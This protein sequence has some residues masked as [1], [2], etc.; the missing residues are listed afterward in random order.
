ESKDQTPE[1]GRND[2]VHLTGLR[3]IQRVT[4]E[5]PTPLPQLTITQ[6]SEHQLV[7]EWDE[8]HGTHGQVLVLEFEQNNAPTIEAKVGI[9]VTPIAVAPTGSDANAGTTS[10]PLRTLTAAFAVASSHDLVTLPAGDYPASLESVP[11][12]A[13][14]TDAGSY[15]CNVPV[16]VALSGPSPTT[17]ARIFDDLDAG[18]AP[19][20]LCG[21][22]KV[23][24]VEVDGFDVGI[25]VVGNGDGF[26][27]QELD[28]IDITGARNAGLYAQAFASGHDVTVESC[29]AGAVVARASGMQ[30][31]LRLSNAVFDDNLG[32]GIV[33]GP[34]C[35]V[36]LGGEVKRNGA[37]SDGGLPGVLLK[38]GIFDPQ[39]AVDIEDNVGDGIDAFGPNPELHSAGTISG[40]RNGIWY[41][42]DG[43]PSLQL[44]GTAITGN[45]EVG[46]RLSG[47]VRSVVWGNTT[48]I[49]PQPIAG[50]RVNVQVDPD[51][52]GTVEF[53][54]TIHFD[55]NDGGAFPDADASG[56]ERRNWSLNGQLLID[57][58][59]YT[60]GPFDWD[61]GAGEGPYN[62]RLL[63]DAGRI[64]F[65]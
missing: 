9:T 8:P 57:D 61:A 34:G 25:A 33:I 32:C 35:D 20:V 4:V 15:P 65:D 52:H 36:V 26:T 6:I 56:H 1:F 37:A 63:S 7:A 46:L 24:N 23:S 55:P 42:A 64:K 45:R 22:N 59:G 18:G 54:R 13:D 53:V 11:R 12:L 28:D 39:A 47:P 17:K 49:D 5:P 31:G 2:G 21:G 41:A 40:N 10:A 19:L 30:C 27:T 51:F 29:G 50:N 60:T 58:A 44:M 3:L 16:D 43:G 62:Y 14:P 38:N 48:E